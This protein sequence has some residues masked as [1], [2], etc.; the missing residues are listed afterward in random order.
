MVTSSSSSTSKLPKWANLTSMRSIDPNSNNDNT[1]T[2]TNTN[3]NTNHRS[4]SSSLVE[5]QL[6]DEA[7]RTCAYQTI[8]QYIHDKVEEVLQTTCHGTIHDI[9]QFLNISSLDND[10]NIKET[11]LLDPT[12]NDCSNSPTS[13]S[14][15]ESVV[16]AYIENDISSHIENHHTEISHIESDPMKSSSSSNVIQNNNNNVAV[17]VPPLEVSQQKYPIASSTCSSSI[18][19]NRHFTIMHHCNIQYDPLLLPLIMIH[20]PFACNDRHVLLSHIMQQLQLYQ[21]PQSPPPPIPQP[22]TTTIT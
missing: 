1:Y 22:T 2:N 10:S 16:T 15:D 20:G 5:I 4:L 12:M 3:T 19:D 14:I 13:N 11:K 9:Q 6:E 21:P 7:I 18:I 17:V 8:K